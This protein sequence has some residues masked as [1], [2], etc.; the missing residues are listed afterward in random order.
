MAALSIDDSHTTASQPTVP[1][2]L[3]PFR[4]ELVSVPGSS[5]LYRT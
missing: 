4:P 3:R 2:S 5:A 1:I